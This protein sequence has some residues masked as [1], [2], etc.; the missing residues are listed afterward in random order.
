M[1]DQP[2]AAAERS[3]HVARGEDSAVSADTRPGFFVIIEG[4]D[5]RTLRYW[6][7][8]MKGGVPF[9]ARVRFSTT[10]PTGGTPE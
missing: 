6:W 8:R 3:A 4:A 5:G 9:G 7:T 1:T 2:T 10:E